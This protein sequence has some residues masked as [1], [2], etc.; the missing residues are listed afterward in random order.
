[1]PLHHRRRAD[2]LPDRRRSRHNFPMPPD[3]LRVDETRQRIVQQP[4]VIPLFLAGIHDRHGHHHP[5]PTHPDSMALAP[6]QG[7]EN[8]GP[9]HL[10]PGQLVSVERYRNAGHSRRGW[11]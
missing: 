7:Q 6:A 9:G 10:S 1:M 11:G 8:R 5:M 4:T 3:C 2:P